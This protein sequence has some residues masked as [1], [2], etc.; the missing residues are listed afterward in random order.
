M[1]KQRTFSL[2][3]LVLLALFSA[4]VVVANPVQLFLD[5]RHGN[6]L[7]IGL[8]AEIQQHT[9]VHAPFQRY[10]IDGQGAF[11]AVHGG[12]IM[13]RRVQVSAGVGPERQASRVVARRFH[14][15]VRLKRRDR[16]AGKHGH[17]VGDGMGQVD[18]MWLAHFRRS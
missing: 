2:F 5:V 16:I 18:E 13:I 10:F 6:T 12:M 8:V 9:V 11:A 7:P 15:V 1:K 4:L 17:A 14:R 3:E